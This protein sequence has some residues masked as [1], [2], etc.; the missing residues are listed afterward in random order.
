MLSVGGIILNN[1]SVAIVLLQ[2]LK[3]EMQQEEKKNYSWAP[4]K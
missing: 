3:K 2:G 1:P 4:E